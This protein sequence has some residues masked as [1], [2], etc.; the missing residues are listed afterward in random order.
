MYQE[1]EGLK[2]ELVKMEKK[3]ESICDQ[4]K[5]LKNE[6][7]SLLEENQDLKDINESL[8]EDVNDINEKIRYL[9]PGH[10]EEEIDE[11]K[12]NNAILKAILQMNR[13]YEK[14]LEDENVV[15]DPNNF[16]ESDEANP[17]VEKSFP[18][19]RCKYSSTSQRGLSVH[20]GLKHKETLPKN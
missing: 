3:L 7:A 20:I 1:N 2:T 4:V 12:E 9:I 14:T 17:T 16:L 19:N 5:V 8:L 15:E 13:D 10:L 6:K 11:L 18:C